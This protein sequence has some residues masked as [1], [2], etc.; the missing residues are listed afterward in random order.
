MQRRK[1]PLSSVVG[2]RNVVGAHA[3]AAVLPN[4]AFTFFAERRCSGRSQMTQARQAGILLTDLALVAT[5]ISGFF[6]FG[7]SLVSKRMF[8]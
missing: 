3:P 6:E 4:R 2:L 1:H 7:N 8:V 5:R